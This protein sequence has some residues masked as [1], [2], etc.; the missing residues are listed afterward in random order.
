MYCIDCYVMCAIMMVNIMNI[1]QNLINSKNRLEIY[2]KNF[3]PKILYISKG[4]ENFK[5]YVYTTTVNI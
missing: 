3:F 2:L 1:V 5:L 4:N